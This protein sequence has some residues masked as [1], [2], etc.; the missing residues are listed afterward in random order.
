[1]PPDYQPPSALGAGK[2]GIVSIYDTVVLRP[3]KSLSQRVEKAASHQPGLKQM[4]RDLLAK[5][6]HG[7]TIHKVNGPEAERRRL[8][9][10]RDARTRLGRG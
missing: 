1:M 10:Q 9:R 5:Y 7:F 4:W 2:T 6:G 3:M 8:T